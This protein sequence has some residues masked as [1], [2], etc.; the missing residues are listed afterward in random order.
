MHYFW[1]VIRQAQN[2]D[3]A[4]AADADDDDDVRFNAA[5]RLQ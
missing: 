4:A 5:I 2:S 3:N 1:F